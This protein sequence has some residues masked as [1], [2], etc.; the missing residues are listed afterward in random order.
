MQYWEKNNTSNF[1]TI[2]SFRWILKLSIVDTEVD[3][4]NL[5]DNFKTHSVTTENTGLKC[6]YVYSFDLIYS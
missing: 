3:A 5:T 6:I 1:S 2:D 4:H